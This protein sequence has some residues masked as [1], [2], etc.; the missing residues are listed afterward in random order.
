MATEFARLT[1]HFELKDEVIDRQTDCKK[2]TEPQQCVTD[3]VRLEVFRTWIFDW[4]V[5]FFSR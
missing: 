4:I 1:D 2:H 3:A 5:I